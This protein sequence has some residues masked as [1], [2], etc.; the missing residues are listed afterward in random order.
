MSKLWLK[1]GGK[2]D[3]G[4]GTWRRVFGDVGREIGGAWGRGIADTGIRDQGGGTCDR[5]SEN[6]EVRSEKRIDRKTA[7]VCSASLKEISFFDLFIVTFFRSVLL[8]NTRPRSHVPASLISCS[9]VPHLTSLHVLASHV[10]KHVSPRRR[11]TFSHSQ[12][13][14]LSA[15]KDCKVFICMSLLSSQEK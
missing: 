11:P 3:L 6:G 2:G 1:V 12:R 13:A 15:G 7:D 14:V 8:Y 10:P 5:G 4:T 9:R